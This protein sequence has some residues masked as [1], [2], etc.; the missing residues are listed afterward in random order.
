MSISRICTCKCHEDGIE[1]IHCM[2]CCSH[3]YKK[4]ISSNGVIDM[5]RFGALE[6]AK[7]EQLQEDYVCQEKCHWDNSDKLHKMAYCT[8]CGLKYI[9]PKGKVDKG[10]LKEAKI[11]RWGLDFVED[12]DVPISPKKDKKL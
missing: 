8:L 3:T 6:K 4:Y 10:R 1:L 12:I 5:E 7:W 2:A 11:K 9:S